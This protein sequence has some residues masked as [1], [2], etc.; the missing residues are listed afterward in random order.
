[1]RREFPK[2]Y[3]ACVGLHPLSD[4]DCVLGRREP[5]LYDYDSPDVEDD[6]ACWISLD[7][8]NTAPSRN[9][10]EKFFIKWGPPTGDLLSERQFLGYTPA[11]SFRFAD[12]HRVA[13]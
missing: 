2:T 7:L 11:G 9:G 4:V 1:V 13:T 12:G 6:K 10:I 8:A 3:V 5:E